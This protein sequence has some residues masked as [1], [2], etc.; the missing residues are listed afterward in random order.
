MQV[1][2]THMCG[3]ALGCHP[4]VLSVPGHMRCIPFSHSSLGKVPLWQ[5]WGPRAAL[6]GLLRP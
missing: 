4:N 1:C 6:P 2:L 5:W 3:Q